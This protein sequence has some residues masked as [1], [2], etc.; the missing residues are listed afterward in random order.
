MHDMGLV[1]NP[2]DYE[3]DHLISLELGG[4]PRD[5]KNLWPQ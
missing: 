4:A 2:K 3:E 1:G 5:P